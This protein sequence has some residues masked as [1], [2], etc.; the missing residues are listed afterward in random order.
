MDPKELVL[1]SHLEPLLLESAYKFP[2]PAV[3]GTY[4]FVG[5]ALRDEILANGMYLSRQFNDLI[6]EKTNSYIASGGIV[7]IYPRH[8]DALPPPLG[9][10]ATGIP[11]G[12]VL[13]MFRLPDVDPA[14]VYYAGEILPTSKGKD[15]QVL[16]QGRAMTG[17]SI[18]SSKI[19][20]ETREMEDGTRVRVPMDG[21]I[22]GIDFADD[23]AVLGAGVVE[24]LENSPKWRE[25]ED[26]TTEDTEM[27]E[28]DKITL[29]ELRGNRADLFS[30]IE[31]ASRK[32][33]LEQISSMEGAAAIVTQER[34]ALKQEIARLEALSDKVAELENKLQEQTLALEKANGD[35]ADSRN[36]A[37]SLMGEKAFYEAAED[38]LTGLVRK[39]LAELC[40]T[41]EDIPAHLQEAKDRA[42]VEFGVVRT[43]STARGKGETHD[44]DEDAPP[45]VTLDAD[46][47]AV[48]RLL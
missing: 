6:I 19:I 21:W 33:L 15:L 28:W 16:I 4:Q 31:E 38:E 42:Y 17:T 29:E 39:H 3:E 27:F 9:S 45:P 25:E 12:R 32:P 48:L 5:K 34:D 11:T 40:E 10:H 47:Q 30:A 46:K 23:P 1:F 14:W 8:G 26:E 41:V 2:K 24:L 37:T 13:E 20:S 22:E 36:V 35:L 44:K 7:T 18:R 43:P